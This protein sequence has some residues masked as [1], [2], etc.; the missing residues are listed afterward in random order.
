MNETDRAGGRRLDAVAVEAALRRLARQ[1]GPSWLHVEV[2]RRLAERL[3]P[4]RAEPARV[5]DWWGGPGGGAGALRERYP[6]AE[7]VAVEPDA[8]WLA[9]RARTNV[10]PWWSF[11]KASARTPHSVADSD[12]TLGRA[13]LVWANMVLHGIVDPPAVFSRWHA[14]LGVD[15]FIA[16]SCLGPGTLRELRELYATLRWPVPT[17][18][19]IDMHDLGD[20]LVAAGFADPVLDQET[21][22]LSWPNAEALLAELRQIGGNAAPDRFAGLRTPAWRRRLAAALAERAGADGRISL[23]FEVA[24]GHGFKAAPRVQG[25]EVAVSLDDMRAMVRRPPRPR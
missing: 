4:I 9:H 6:K 25:G 15:G 16:F 19:F 10:R 23:S 3:V 7:I 13:Q 24:Y 22:A 21:L 5:L 2:A 1:A 14:L 11:G 17:P 8:A 20:M 18:G 12:A